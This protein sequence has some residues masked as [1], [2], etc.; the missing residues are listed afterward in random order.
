MGSVIIWILN[1]FER[2]HRIRFILS[3]TMA[4]LMLLKGV[5]V[6]FYFH[7]QYESEL[8]MISEY[9]V[10]RL[11]QNITGHLSLFLH[12][13]SNAI[14][15][16][17][18]IYSEKDNIRV[19]DLRHSLRRKM[20]G[21]LKVIPQMRSITLAL[22]DGNFMLIERLSMGQARNTVFGVTFQSNDP[23]A[24]TIKEYINEW[25]SVIGGENKR[26]IKGIGT[27][28]NISF[29][30]ID[31]TDQRKPFERHWYKATRTTHKQFWSK[32][33]VS[34]ENE[35][36]WLVV[37]NPVLN[38]NARFIGAISAEIGLEALNEKLKSECT[39]AIE[40]VFLF[41]TTGQI[42][43]HPWIH[44]ITWRENMTLPRVEDIKEYDIN[45]YF[46]QY[47]S[48]NSKAYF[49]SKKGKEVVYFA[50][51]EHPT[52]KDWHICVVAKIHDLV[53]DIEK[54]QT[55]MFWFAVISTLIAY[56][57][58]MMIAKRIAKSVEEV[59]K[60][61][62]EIQNLSFDLEPPKHNT[63]FK[64]IQ[65]MMHS[66]TG[67]KTALVSFRKFV[68]TTLVQQLVQTGQGAQC[69]GK[70]KELTV[71]FSDIQGFSSVVEQTTDTSLIFEHMSEYFEEM[72]QVIKSFRGTIDKYIGDAIMAFWGAPIDEPMHALLACEAAFGCVK[73]L[74]E[75]NPIWSA[76]NL[77]PMP[78]RFGIS[79]GEMLVGN[80]GSSDR[81]QYTLLGDKVNVGARL[82]PLNKRYGTTILMSETTYKN[83][84]NKIVSRPV[85]EVI[86]HGKKEPVKVYEPL[87]SYDQE[88][89]TSK[90]A[91]PKAL[92]K[93]VDTEDAF[94]LYQNG[95]FKEAKAA[96]E[97]IL[98][99][100]PS[101][102]LAQIFALRCQE[103]INDPPKN[104]KGIFKY[105]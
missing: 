4:T 9:Q 66:L 90:E 16:A 6:L 69:E 23:D 49:T 96:Y 50:P 79:T 103:L 43:S 89:K 1:L 84:W 60:D 59:A 92:R 53:Q 26:Q 12:S 68:P 7:K 18:W 97:S 46:H 102:K 104:W 30:W 78:T 64:E 44:R 2:M 40:N 36:L 51:I 65:E 5:G 47:V 82:E 83:V 70:K 11:Q 86:L 85:D 21:F 63:S 3:L 32:I 73:K 88:S 67:V 45:N 105:E 74:N 101:D 81:L 48:N 25:G 71:L 31:L 33:Y 37:S 98:K 41:N 20:M 80:I 54:K 61:L 62:E 77:S 99:Q 13:A 14:Q 58:G 56:M 52:L 55:N 91:L 15:A 76:R 19:I 42:L 95:Y 10:T 38:Q 94:H 100:D 39:G 27:M 72:T 28:D 29:D 57:L 35:K 8:G 87:A 34:S 22:E 75:I 17:S 24:P 93:A